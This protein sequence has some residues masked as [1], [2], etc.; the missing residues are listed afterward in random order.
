[1]QRYFFK[2]NFFNFDNRNMCT[3]INI[4]RY[5]YSPFCSNN[6]RTMEEGGQRNAHVYKLGSFLKFHD[7]GSKNGETDPRIG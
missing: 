7:T 2:I 5:S 4:T 1:M 3:N 6:N